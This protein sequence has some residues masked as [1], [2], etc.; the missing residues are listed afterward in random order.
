L[1]NRSEN[2]YNL[3]VA[4]L[5]QA[6]SAYNNATEM[7][8]TMTNFESELKTKQDKASEAEGFK[9]EIIANLNDSTS[10]IENLKKNLE[11]FRAESKI[12]KANLDYVES[13]TQVNKQSF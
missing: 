7:L 3:T 4:S 5:K 12:I 2:A 11:N 10:L 9:G 8:E 1:L 6:T 13:S